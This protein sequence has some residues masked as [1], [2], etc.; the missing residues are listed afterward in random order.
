MWNILFTVLENRCAVINEIL[1]LQF[2]FTSH[3]ME[4]L[5]LKKVGRR[6]ATTENNFAL[7]ISDLRLIPQPIVW[8]CFLTSE[9]WEGIEQSV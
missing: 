5:F 6:V 4:P 3:F 1:A 2:L 8:S 9:A 7:G